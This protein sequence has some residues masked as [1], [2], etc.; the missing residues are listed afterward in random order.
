M[1]GRAFIL[2]AVMCGNAAAAAETLLFVDDHEVLYRSG[3][4]RVI[5]TLEKFKGNPVVTPDNPERPWEKSVQWVSVHHDPHTGKMQMWYQAFSGKGAEDKRFKSVVAYAE[6]SDGITWMKPKLTLFPYRER[7]FDVGETNIVLVGA[8]DGYGDRYANSVVV[9]AAEA[10]PARKYKMAFYDWNGGAGEQGAA[11]LCVAFSPD[12]IHWTR[13]GGV[14]MPT[15]FGSKAMQPPF[16]DES[17]YLEVKKGDGSTV[18]NW[19][20]PASLSDAADA[21]WDARLGRYVIYGKMWFGGPDGGLNWKHGMGRSESADFLH[22]SK[23]QLVL[24]TDERDP[25]NLEFHT[26][27]AFIRHGVYFSLNQL[28][29]REN[30]T[31]DNELMTSRDGIRWNRTRQPV[32]ARGGKSSFDAGFVLTNGNPIEMGDELW[33]YYG[34]NR[35]LVRFPNPDEPDMPKRTTQFGSGIGLAKI[36]RDRFAGIAPDPLAS[37]RNWNPN[38][39]SRK[40]E[41]AA[42]TIGQITLKP[43]DFTG[44]KSIALNADAARGAVR[45]EVLSEEG[46]RLRGFTKDD[47]IPTTADA[48]DREV[49][50]RDKRLSDLPPGRHMLRVHLDR[51]ELFA[52]MLK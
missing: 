19:R 10:D 49:R 52:I 8:K 39:P 46:Y 20:Y 3:T 47:A 24:T 4:R 26:S 5:H 42:N 31:I 25:A 50:W 13:Q 6:S 34:G 22:W 9:N 37:L 1:N 15:A 17:V 48:L 16:E 40:P 21:L 45:V 38:D 36:K 12:G 2:A 7:G 43:R 30:G 11:G 27:P 32:L 29:T 51:A 18:R 23:P 44:V 35:G 33:F 41:P 14:V 28:F